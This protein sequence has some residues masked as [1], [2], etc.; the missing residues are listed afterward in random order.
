MYTVAKYKTNDEYEYADGTR[1]V[2]LSVRPFWA[3][4]DENGRIEQRKNPLTEWLHIFTFSSKKK[5][6]ETC[7]RLNRIANEAN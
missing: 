6:V 2:N 4:L 7:A 3:I 1:S 5:A